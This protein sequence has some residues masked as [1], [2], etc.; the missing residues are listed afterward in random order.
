MADLE[1]SSDGDRT[2]TLSIP[3]LCGNPVTQ[4]AG[5]SMLVVTG[6]GYALV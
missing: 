5:D 6:L 2:G 3:A 4:Q 1:E